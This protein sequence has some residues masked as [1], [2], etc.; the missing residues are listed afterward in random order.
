MEKNRRRYLFDII[1]IVSLLA[2]F[3]CLFLFFYGKEDA[4][5]LARIYIENDIAAEYP[6][7][8]DGE[9]VINGGTNILKI[10]DGRAYMLYADCPDGWCKRQG[11]I[12]I[13]GE[14]ITCLPNRVTVVIEEGE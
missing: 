10:E 7:D 4:G 2:V 6:L 14:R 1:L 9:Y 11:K 8:K 12:Y 5:A 3:L 13:L